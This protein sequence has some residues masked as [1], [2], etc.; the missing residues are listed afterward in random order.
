MTARHEHAAADYGIME[1]MGRNRKGGDP[2][3]SRFA[4]N[5]QALRAKK[6]P[7]AEET[8][9]DAAADAEPQAEAAAPAARDR[10]T[11]GREPGT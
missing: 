10:S 11:V 5:L 8:A 3:A 4:A 2:A 7:P 9:A 1:P 6:K